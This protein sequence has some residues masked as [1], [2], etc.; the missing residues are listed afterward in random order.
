MN[1][2]AWIIGL[3]LLTPAPFAVAQMTGPIDTGR[4]GTERIQLNRAQPAQATP[5]PSRPAAPAPSR[6]LDV[7]AFFG[8]FAGSGV[9][10]GED[11]VY[12]GVTQRDLDVRISGA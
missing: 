5:V 7:K 9:A 2:Y 10:D 11:T 1:R 6:S 4:T 12:L 3:L 8:S